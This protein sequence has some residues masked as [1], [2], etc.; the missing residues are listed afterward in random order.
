M[1]FGCICMLLKSNAMI[2][3]YH[4]AYDTFSG[5]AT[6]SN[7]TFI[8]HD[9]V[10]SIITVAQISITLLTTPPAMHPKCYIQHQTPCTFRYEGG[11]TFLLISF[12]TYGGIREMADMAATRHTNPLN[13][14]VTTK[15]RYTMLLTM[16]R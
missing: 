3:C 14:L 16:S 6:L 4:E 15:F 12:A 9:T 8:A 1:V 7:M 5:T 13:E 10:S 11:L 2:F